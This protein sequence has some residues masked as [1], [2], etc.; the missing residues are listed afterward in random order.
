MA[1][2][3][4]LFPAPKEPTKIGAIECDVLIEQEITLSSDVTEHP[5]EDGFPV[6]DHVIRKPLKL[7]M[8][9]AI[10]NMPVTWYD[11]FGSNSQDRMGDA[12]SKLEGIYKAGDPITV[13]TQEKVYDNMV[14]TDCRIPKNREN[15]K[16]LK[17][18]L[19]FTQIRKVQVKTAEI[20]AEYVDALTKGKA[21]ETN[22][23]AGTATT[24]DISANSTDSS[25]SGSQSTSE[26]SKSILKGVFG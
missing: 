4:F 26:K 16:V 18:P 1:D 21:G 11:R 9:I 8:T 19:E 7:A 17:V 6:H 12:V 3:V 23:D 2:A 15:G 24:Q 25:S 14:M 20:P 5:V 10:S 13:V 22:Q